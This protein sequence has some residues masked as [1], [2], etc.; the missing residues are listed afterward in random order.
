MY[1][2]TIHTPSRPYDRSHPIPNAT[3]VFKLDATLAR[4]DAWHDAGDDL[5][6]TDHFQASALMKT[7]RAAPRS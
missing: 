4:V 1:L 3:G 6:L 7:S 2:F 5:L